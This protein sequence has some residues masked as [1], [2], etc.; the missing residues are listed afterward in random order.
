MS[1]PESAFGIFSVLRFRCMAA[2]L[3]YYHDCLTAYQYI[4]AKGR[5]YIS[6][7]NSSG[8][9]QDQEK[10]LNIGK[11]ILKK[12]D[13]TRLERPSVFENEMLSHN[14]G[15]LKLVHGPLGLQ[16]G[17]MQW[18]SLF[19]GFEDYQAWILPVAGPQGK[20]TMAWI[21]FEDETQLQRFLEKNTLD[22]REISG[23]TGSDEKYTAIRGRDGA[24]LLFEGPLTKT[25]LDQ[26]TG[27]AN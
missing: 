18:D 11:S 16:N 3:H 8:S 5:Y 23:F 7:S 25:T 21:R 9:P 1:S 26:V 15:N 17:F 20:F 19:T 2:G 22:L 14:L 27:P 13:D 12:I 24:L 4:A 10:I 6:V